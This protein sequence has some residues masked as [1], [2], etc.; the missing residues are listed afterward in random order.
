MPEHFSEGVYFTIGEKE[1][2]EYVSKLKEENLDLIVII[3]HL[4]YP[5]DLK[6]AKNVNG[7]DILLSAHT[8]NRIYSP[9][10]INNTLIIQSGCH[11]S[12]L[13]KIDLEVS[14]KKIV[15]YQHELI[16]ISANIESD[17]EIEQ[18]LQEVLKDDTDFL[19]QKIGRTDIPLH[20]YGALEA[21]MDNLLLDSMIDLT[22]A[23][24]AFSNGWRYGAPI[25]PGVITMNDL[26]NIIPVNPFISTTDISGRDVWKMMEENLERTF[27]RN[28]YQQMGGYVKR[29]SGLQMYFKVENPAGE[30][31]QE[32]FIKNKPIEM[33]KI[34]KSVFVTMQGVPS[35]YGENRIQT[36]VRAIANLKD[37]I[38]RTRIVN[39]ELKKHI[40]LV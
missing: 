22:G 27:S 21:T 4:G 28:P 15:A 24:L 13:G 14:N 6:I 36:D 11:G 33:D 1:V 26:Y 3:S 23:E 12:F 17:P 39:P 19:E 40:V 38:Q 9:A 7:I 25:E 16:E 5:Q 32:L 20:R 29:S 8:H 35:K 10:R 37:Y 2:R 30:R 34:Y 18:M 31:I